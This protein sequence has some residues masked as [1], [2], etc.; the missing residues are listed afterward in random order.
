[1]QNSYLK[2]NNKKKLSSALNFFSKLILNIYPSV[3]LLFEE[4]ADKEEKKTQKQ[5]QH[6]PKQTHKQKQCQKNK[7]KKRRV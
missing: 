7:C 5:Q 3:V 6:Q 1:M 2:T 4:I